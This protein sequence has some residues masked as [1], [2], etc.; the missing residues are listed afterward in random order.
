MSQSDSLPRVLAALDALE[1]AYLV[2]GS[3]ASS[4]HGVSR[5]TFDVDLLVG[6]PARHVVDFVAALGSGFY[7][8]ELEIKRSVEAGRSFNVIST[9]D[10]LKFDFF[11]ATSPYDRS[12]LERRQLRNAE[13]FGSKLEVAVASAEDTILNKLRWYRLGGH[14]SERQW[15]DLLG[16]L[17]VRA[18]KLDRLYLTTWAPQLGVADLLDRL[19]SSR[20]G[21]RASE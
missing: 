18:A 12:Q 10:V 1:V 11:P 8:D 6:L 19:F 13:L 4:L 9:A 15:S 14:V 5:T 16:I 7:A 2:S 3:I 17:D 21:H 20:S